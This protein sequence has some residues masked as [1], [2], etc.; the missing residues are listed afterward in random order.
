MD[1]KTID[2]L[3]YRIQQEQLSSRIY[4]QMSLWLDNKG[5]K[6]FSTLYS[7]YSQEELEHADWAKHYLL[8]YGI[9]PK[10]E[11]LEAPDCSYTCLCDILEMTLDHEKE[12][13]RQCTLLY[14]YAT[15][16]CIG[17]L[18]AL[19]LKYLTE[20]IEEQDKAQTLVDQSKLTTDMLLFDN[21]IGENYLD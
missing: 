18:V 17:T 1:K 10:L 21:Y 13:T 3:N 12:I 7:K 2:I 5:Y 14:E 19:S 20:Q 9:S 15:K 6:N 11:K 4:E 8:S 16:N